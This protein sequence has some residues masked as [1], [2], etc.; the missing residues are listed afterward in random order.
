MPSRVF[1]ELPAKG[2]FSARE[3]YSWEDLQMLIEYGRMRGVRVLPE[4]EMPGH[5]AAWKAA[6]PEIFADMESTPQPPCC[7][8]P[9]APIW[10]SNTPSP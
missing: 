9:G 3:Q 5:S 2:A 7:T 1:P 6:H 4:F 8:R 10:P